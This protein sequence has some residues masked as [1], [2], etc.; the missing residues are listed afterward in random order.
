MLRLTIAT[1]DVIKHDK[2]GATMYKAYPNL[3]H[4]EG[5]FYI[6]LYV[7]VVWIWFPRVYICNT[8]S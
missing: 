2:V 4:T 1:C 7:S 3:V 5:Y 8:W 6:I